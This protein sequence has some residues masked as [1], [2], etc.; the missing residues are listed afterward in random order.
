MTTI[1]DTLDLLSAPLYPPEDLADH[2]S[3]DVLV[4][5][6]EAEWVAALATGR[7]VVGLPQ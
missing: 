2:L 7:P 4:A 1:R 3:R 5:R 6:S